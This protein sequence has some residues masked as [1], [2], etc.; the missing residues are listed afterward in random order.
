MKEKMGATVRNEMFWKGLAWGL[1]LLVANGVFYLPF[2]LG[3]GG[4]GDGSPPV[5]NDQGV[6]VANCPV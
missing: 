4:G 3:C 2:L 1:A 6:C 5:F